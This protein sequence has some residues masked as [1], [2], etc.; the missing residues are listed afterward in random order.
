[1]RIIV[2]KNWLDLP[3]VWN[4]LFSKNDSATPYQSF[5]FQNFTGKGKPQRRDLFRL[6]GIREFN[7]VLY[8]DDR[9]IAIAPLLIKKQRGS[10]MVYMRGHFTTADHLDFIHNGWSY[11][12]MRFLLDYIKSKL[13]K[14]T[15]HF[16]RI[17]EHFVTCGYLERYFSDAKIEKNECYAIPVP[18]NYDEWLG[19]LSKSVRQNL[20][21]AENRL[22]KDQ[23]D[24]NLQFIIGSCVKNAVY[25]DMLAVYADRFLV[26]NGIDFGFF[27][28]V[29]KKILSGYLALD[30]MSKWL[31]IADNNFHAILYLN[32]EVAAFAS[33]LVFKDGRLLTSR[34]NILSKYARYSPGGLLISAIIR[35]VTKLKMSGE[36]SI[37]KMD[38]SQEGAKQNS[39]K[40]SYGGELYYNYTFYG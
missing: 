8:S 6:L 38:L 3:V 18:Q 12:D 28:G 9:P 22:H 36:L 11:E 26:K 20:R 2:E 29:V 23:V 15:F 39:Y 5:E 31:Q 24:F 40:I 21:T 27:R 10:Y 37:N 13:G 7:L 25:S 30:K 14:V 35:H 19:G 4:E 17:P 33:G 16:D 34:L 1:M 32:G